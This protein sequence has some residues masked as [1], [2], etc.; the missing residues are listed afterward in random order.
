MSDQY[1]GNTLFGWDVKKEQR[2]A[3][4]MEHLFDVYRPSNNCYTGLWQRFCMGEAGEYCK[5]MYFDRLAAL[6]EYLN[7]TNENE[8][9]IATT[10]NA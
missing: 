6:Q 7:T 4:F 9:S 10:D 3:D 1:Q 5:D 8:S 2:K